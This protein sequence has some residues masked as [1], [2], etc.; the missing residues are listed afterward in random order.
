M[1]KTMLILLIVLI[2]IFL[3]LVTGLVTPILMNDVPLFKKPGI[4]TRL[5]A[6]LGNNIVETS[7]DPIFPELK[8]PTVEYDFDTL[9]EKVKSFCDRDHWEIETI[10]HKNQE[11]HLV[12][13]TPMMKFQDDMALRLETREGEYNLLHIRSASRI[14]KGDLGANLSHVLEIMKGL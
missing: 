3:V 13:T 10:D 12:I 11:I 8:T 7:E 5:P 4:T 6:Y 1:K 14:G 2:G 9:T